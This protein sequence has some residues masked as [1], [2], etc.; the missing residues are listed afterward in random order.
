MKRSLLFL[1]FIVFCLSSSA[2]E[3]NKLLKS[4]PVQQNPSLANDSLLAAYDLSP[5]WLYTQNSMVF[6]YIG[7]GY[8]RIRVKFI[9]ITK[10]KTANDVYHVY[11]KSMVKT[12]ITEFRGTLKINHI[13]KRIT[14]GTDT[15]KYAITGEYNFAESRDLPH[16]GIFKGFFVSKIYIDKANKV[17]YDDIDLNA[18]S[19]ANNQFTGDWNNYN[20]IQVQRCNWGDYRIPNSGDFDGGAGEFFPNS[21]Y[22][23]MGWQNVVDLNAGGEKGAQAKKEEEREWW[24]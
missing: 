11:G 4:I 7:E 9:T 19:F 16:S 15:A 20:N 13:L 18:D 6:G 3:T 23:S 24:K 8:L 17:H 1:L 10:D 5:I 22:I 2:Q 14:A 12:N 21:K